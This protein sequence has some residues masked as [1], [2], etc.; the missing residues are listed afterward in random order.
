[1]ATNRRA[2]MVARKH[3]NVMDR[4]EPAPRT[5]VPAFTSISKVGGDTVSFTREKSRTT[6]AF[7]EEWNDLVLGD[8]V[9][10]GLL[11]Q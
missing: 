10:S 9:R 5:V 4:V 1:M 6:G 11:G 2:Q 8:L 3:V 7:W